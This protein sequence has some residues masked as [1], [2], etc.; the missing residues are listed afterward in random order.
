MEKSRG[1]IGLVVVLIVAAA[2][3]WFVFD[4]SRSEKITGQGSSEIIVN[5]SSNNNLSA[6]T[7]INSDI[8]N[9]ITFHLPNIYYPD[10]QSGESKVV[11]FSLDNPRIG[12]TYYQMR[13]NVI[14]NSQAK[15]VVVISANY[16]ASGFDDYLVLVSNLNSTPSQTAYTHINGGHPLRINSMTF[17][18]NIVTIDAT[19]TG[20]A[21]PDVRQEI[22][23]F[24]VKNN[25]FEKIN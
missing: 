24:S 23:E 12:S 10:S 22:L 11:G 14:D 17:D 13:K 8:L 3:A 9:K 6:S 15:A 7:T 4:Q 16:G 21:G 25:S 5:N 1:L 18:N 19:I 2:V 20:G